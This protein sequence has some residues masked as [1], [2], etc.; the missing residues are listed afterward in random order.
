MSSTNNTI[1]L[2]ITNTFSQIVSKFLISIL[3]I[4]FTMYVTRKFGP[5]IYGEYIYYLTIASTFSVISDFGISISFIKNIYKKEE[6]SIFENYLFLKLLLTVISFILPLFLFL[7]NPSFSKNNLSYAFL[8]SFVVAIGNYSSIIFTFIQSKQKIYL[9]NL[10]DILIR[11]LIV[12]FSIIGT[13]VFNTIVVLFIVLG[14]GNILYILIGKI[15]FSKIDI[16]LNFKKIE[17]KTIYLLFIDS[18]KVGVS[19]ILLVLYFKIDLYLLSF[20]SNSIKVGYYG[21]SYKIF[22]NIIMLWGFFM[23]TIYP[24]LAK[25]YI[26][27]KKLFYKSLKYTKYL[28]I[29]SGLIILVITNFLSQFI[30][31]FIS[32]NSYKESSEILKIISFAIPFL[33]INNVF[34]YEY[35]IKNKIFQINFVLFTALLINLILNIIFLPIYNIIAASYITIITEFYIL[36][37]YLFINISKSND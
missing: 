4:V 25:Y 18:F 3:S 36:V 23:A 19:S 31:S 2:I 32:G 7:L 1:R 6:E 11:L 33:F 16:Q 17:Y 22:E 12:I 27:N 15:I 26:N 14:I 34:Y 30:I 8:A 35:V 5:S 21:L 28:S 13:Y 10:L 24:L 37:L 9:F 29:I 20:F